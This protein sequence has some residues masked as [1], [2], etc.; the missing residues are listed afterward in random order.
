[1]NAWAARRGQ[2]HFSNEELHVPTYL[3][4]RTVP[5]AAQLSRDQL[6]AIAAKSCDVV[7]HLDV[8]YTWHETFVAGDKLFCVHSA[9]SADVVREHARR[10]GFPV[11]R[12]TEIAATIGPHT[13]A[14]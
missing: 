2:G 14:R 13:A 12:I 7:N 4:E 11:D 6:Q 10:G 3:I 9:P 8:P 1:V 5:G